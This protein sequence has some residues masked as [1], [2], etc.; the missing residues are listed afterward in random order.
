MS[1]GE[2]LKGLIEEREREIVVLTR[3]LEVRNTGKGSSAVVVL[4]LL[5][6]VNDFPGFPAGAE[7]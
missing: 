1:E 3:K 2:R 6:Q 5:L 7:R 4:L